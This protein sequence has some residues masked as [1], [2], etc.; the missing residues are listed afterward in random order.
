[1]IA[2]DGE[3]RVLLVRHSYGSGPVEPAR[4]RAWQQRGSAGRA[5]CREFAEELGCGLTGLRHVA[6][7]DETFHGARNEAHMCYRPDRWHAPRPDRREIVEARFFAWMPCRRTRCA[8]MVA[9]R[10]RLLDL[11]QA[12]LPVLQLAPLSLALLLAGSPG[13]T[14]GSGGAAAVRPPA[15]RG[16]CAAKV[17]AV[18]HRLGQERASGWRC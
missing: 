9:E 4:R 12:Q 11:E 6:T 8:R 16:P 17:G 5:P 7:L 18:R 10:L 14:G 15:G 1:M 2:R 3:G 13:S